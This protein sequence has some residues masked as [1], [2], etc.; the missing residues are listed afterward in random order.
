M[1]RFTHLIF[2]MVLVFLLFSCGE[3]KGQTLTFAFLTDTHIGTAIG[4]K[5]L[6]NS[7]RDI[8][9]IP[10]IEFVLLAGDVTEYDFDDELDTV[11]AILDELNVPYHIIPGNH[12]LKWSASGGEKF[13]KLYED[14]KFNVSYKGYRFIGVNQGPLM[15]MGEGFIAREDLNWTSRQLKKMW[16]RKRQPVFFVT[17]YPIDHTVT[18]AYDFLEIIKRYN[19]QA[20]MHGHGHRNRLNDYSDIPGIMGRSNLSRGGPG[21][22][23]IVTIEDGRMTWVERLPVEKISHEPW[24][25]LE[26]KDNVYTDS[27]KA[28]KPDMSV[29]E[30]YPSVKKAWSYD[31]EYS[32]TA[33]A[34]VVDDLVIFGNRSGKVRALSLKD[35]SSIWV[36]RTGG[37]VFT[38]PEIAG[39]HVYVTSTDSSLYCLDYRTG[40]K[41]WSYKTKA[42]I[43]A[44]P[45][46]Y[47]NK[48]YFGASDGKFRALDAATGALVWDFMRIDTYVETKPLMV[49]GKII[50]GAWDTYLYALDANSGNLVWRWRGDNTGRLYSPA[51]V[52]PVYAN[53]KVFIVA[54]DRVMT[55]IDIKNGKT[56]WRSDAF[57]VRENIGISQDAST[58]YAKTMWDILCAISTKG[59]K[60][61]TRWSN[62]LGYGFE[63][64]P[65]YPVEHEGK[66]YF[67]TQFGFV[68]ALNAKDGELLWVHRIGG[69]LLNTPIVRN[70]SA[71]ITGMD[72]VVAKITF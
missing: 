71:V 42:P 3:Q 19:A 30:K 31:S 6:R 67:T 34:A 15:R 2:S 26:L 4:A 44:H 59:D 66:V 48:V 41:V 23:N 35:G 40:K 47:G 9:T 25:V 28:L 61:Q 70:R 55:A 13:R 32:I 49:A 52:H 54:P 43:V 14:D 58:V 33:A 64:D 46:V 10:E 22:Y 20:I 37:P 24:L 69:N 39:D 57:R 5:D 50:F 27:H 36:F 63:I 53:G 17:H 8:N 11:K 51:V 72:G 60:P 62:D 29:N 1:R 12:E 68:Y 56:V 38:E 7:V 65:S 18:N 45:L 16:P 21:G